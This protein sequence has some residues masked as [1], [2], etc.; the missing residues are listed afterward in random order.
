LKTTTEEILERLPCF[1]RDEDFKEAIYTEIKGP[2]KLE[3]HDTVVVVDK[4][5][6]ESVMLGADVY[7]PGV[8]NIK[9]KGKEVSVI[10]DNGV[11]VGEGILYNS[12]IVVKVA[13]SLYNSVKIGELREIKDGLLYSQGKASMYVGK[14]V[15]PQP[16]ET[17]V[18]MTA[19]PGGKLT[20]IYQL[21]PKARIIGFDH[22]HKKIDKMRDLLNK[23]GVNAELYVKDSRYA[24]DIVKNVDKVIIDPPCSA[25]GIR[26]KIYDKKTK[27]DILNFYTYQK[28][29]LNSA[30]KILKDGGYVIYSTCTV[31]TWENEKVIEDPRFEVEF[32]IRFHPNIH[33][34]TGFFIAKLKKK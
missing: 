21:E 15:D 31:T 8:K 9:G 29:F 28:Q 19:S 20:H 13:K 16:S 11:L 4:R 7:K 12:D 10:S 18:D 6:A 26:P 1:K 5:T 27:M 22:T 34:M 3:L 32:S 14:I 30:Y 25:L 33:D 23:L 17:I 2:N 24:E